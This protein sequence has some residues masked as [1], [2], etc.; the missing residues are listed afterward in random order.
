MLR[1]F[2]E[3]EERASWARPFPESFARHR[4]PHGHRDSKPKG[5]GKRNGNLWTLRSLRNTLLKGLRENLWGKILRYPKYSVE[6]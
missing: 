1:A 5:D 4:Q 6:F 3:I 2:E